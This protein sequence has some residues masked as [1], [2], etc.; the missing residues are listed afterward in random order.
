LQLAAATE[1]RVRVL[2]Y[3]VPAALATLL[4]AMIVVVVTSVGGSGTGSRSARSR[5]A[6]V[7]KLPAYWTVRPG[8]TYSQIARKTG[9]T[10]DQLEQFNPYTD[11]RSLVPG[12]R[13]KLSL[14]PRSRPGRRGPR[15]WAVRRGESFG[16][17][18]AKT[19]ISIVTLERLNP[20]LKPAT[21]QPGDQVRLRR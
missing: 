12:Q 17:I 20:R 15:F 21:L 9:L 11:P 10:I 18:A 7:R 16:L 5:H 13:L 2:R 14:H 8:E 4:A 6:A 1:P 19:G 3:L